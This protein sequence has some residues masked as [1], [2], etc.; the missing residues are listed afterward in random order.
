MAN[1]T[2][3]KLRDTKTWNDQEYLDHFRFFPNLQHFRRIIFDAL[4]I[5]PVRKWNTMCGTASINENVS[6][7]ARDQKLTL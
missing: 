6:L 3:S 7:L 2:L 1:K 5:G 4:K